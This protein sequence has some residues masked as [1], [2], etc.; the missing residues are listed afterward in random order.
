MYKVAYRNKLFSEKSSRQKVKTL[1]MLKYSVFNIHY[2]IP[3]LPFVLY[4][5]FKLVLCKN[6]K[7]KKNKISV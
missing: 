3:I 4:N 6:V 2:I 1:K 5:S 7:S